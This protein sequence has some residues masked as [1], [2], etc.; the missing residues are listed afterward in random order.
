MPKLK[1][2]YIYSNY[3]TNAIKNGYKLIN[4]FYNSLI[5]K[6]IKNITN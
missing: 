6:N 1:T 2:N 3:D 5:N 4:E